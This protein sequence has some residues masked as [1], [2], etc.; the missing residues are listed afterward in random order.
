MLGAALVLP[1]CTVAMGDGDLRTRGVENLARTATVEASSSAGQRGAKY[2]IDS[3]NDGDLGTWWA[4]AKSPE[5]PVSITVTFAEP[6][7]IDCLALVQADNPSIYTNCKTVRIAFS[8]GSSLEQ[9]FEDS[10]APKLIRFGERTVEWLKVEILEPYDAEKYYVTLREIMA[11]HDPDRKVATK[12]PPAVQWKNA[13]VTPQGRDIHPCV[14]ITPEDVELA[15]GRIETDEWARS[16]FEGVRK[17]ADEWVSKDDVWIASILPE[18][19]ACFAYGFTACPICRGSWGQWGGARCSFDNPGHVT[20]A[21]GHVL[22]DEE[23]PDPGA[24]YQ[25]PDGRIHYFVGSYNAWVVETLQFTALKSLA[26]A[27]TLTGDDR[28]AEKAAFILDRL[29]DLYPSCDKGSW[30]Y[31]SDPPSGRFCRPWYQVARVLIHYVDWYDLIFPSLALDKPSVREGLSRRASIETNLLQNGATYCYTQSLK[32]RL[33]NGEADYIRGAL[34]VGCCLGVP[35]YIDWAHDGPYGILNLVRNNVDRDGRYFETSVMYA[36]HTRDLYLTFAEPLLNYRSEKYPNGINLYDD[37]QFQ[38]FYVL[39]ELSFLCIGKEPRFG[40][41]GPDT[42]RSFLPDQPTSAFDYRLAE[43]LYA[44]VSA[45]EDRAKFGSLLQ[46]LSGGNVAK[47][48]ATRAEMPWLLF[49]G[50]EPLDGAPG[51]LHATLRRRI[52]E[53][54]FFGQ[55]GIGILRAGGDADARAALI[56]FGP[57]LNHGHHDDLNLNYYALGYEVSYDLGYGLGSTHTQVGWSRQTASHNLVLVD[58]TS[59]GAAD[60]GTGGSLHHFA[61][62]PGLKLVE[63][64][65]DNS[66]VQQ[67]VTTYRRLLALIGEGPD[68]YLVDVFRVVGGAQ[69]DYLFHSLSDQATFEGV[70]L[71][72]AENGSLAGPDIDWG[73]KQ[74]NDGDMAGFPNKPY[75][76]PP[77]GN[78]LGFLME[79]RRAKT[80]GEW[81]A[82][83]PLPSGDAFLRLTMVGQPETEVTS[84]WAPGIY[85]RHPKARYAVARRR[86][87]DGP[88]TS[89]FVAVLEPYGRRIAGD[90]TTALD[91]SRDASASAGELK[92]IDGI[93]VL[94]HKASEK[95][96]EVRWSFEVEREADYV[97]FLDHYESP[98]YGQVQLLADGQPVGQP[99][100]G[101][102]EQVRAAP[103]CRVGQVHLAAGNHEAALR[104]TADDGAGHYWFGLR[105][106]WLVPANLADT[107]DAVPSIQ[108][109]RPL[110]CEDTGGPLEAAGLLITLDEAE[111]VHDV[112]AVEGY[113]DRPRVFR[114]GQYQ[115]GLQGAFAHVRMRSGHAHQVHLIDTTSLTIGDLK[116]TCA[117]PELTGSVR[118]VNEQE[119]AIETEARLP[120]D[121]RLNGQMILFENAGYSRN[122]PHRIARVEPLPNGSRIVLESPSLILGTGILE[123]DPMDD[124]QFTSLLAHEYARSDSVPGTQFL[125]GKR[126]EGDGFAT[127]IVRTHFGQIMRYEVESTEGMTQGDEF[128][129]CDVQAGD[130]FRIPTMAY[131]EGEADGSFSGTATTEVTVRRAG[132]EVVRIAPSSL[133]KTQ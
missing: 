64:S 45:P 28:Y 31:P 100:V 81:S 55:K 12:M 110:T 71:G 127:R 125:S 69:H 90:E 49:H 53:S 97:V 119:A 72:E 95:G 8:D 3:A 66:Y 96:D 77:P 4:S 94:L 27:Y 75:W 108:D 92:Y 74:L 14:Y 113:T 79:P 70:T 36:D 15:R 26:Y 24:G 73:A 35:W 62:L 56:R 78:G 104:H 68:A 87:E 19:G 98:S 1:L 52:S 44:R 102:G 37:P 39:P 114:Q 67:G 50:A 80:D 112:I 54:D 46:F 59:Q 20:C 103:L 123:D 131:V 17:Q 48:R 33:H 60:S 42:A 22:P 5:Y 120:A 121:G 129:I 23:H 29:A 11:F 76:N 116:L 132:T 10:S 34:A 21:N 122:T 118:D 47:A 83:W 41:S 63:A 85:P 43:R 2:G 88:L 101:T 25:G 93:N 7:T 57:T 106:M 61:D 91:I 126:I 86:S 82:T 128:I 40:D 124:H 107:T 99:I 16:W 130:T 18:P 117:E 133:A 84:A 89:N 6:Q 51:D 65:S 109:I 13:D 32:G 105:A 111:G 30:D 115:L 58:E 38:S 9:A